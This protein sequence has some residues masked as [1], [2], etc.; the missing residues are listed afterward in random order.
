MERTDIRAAELSEKADI[1]VIDVSFISLI[2]IL[3]SVAEL[4]K[5]DGKI[6]AMMKPQF[7]AG[8]TVADEHKGLILD[9]AVRQQVISDFRE[10]IETQFAVEAEADSGVPGLHGNRERFFVLRPLAANMA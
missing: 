4:V 3:R 1:A 9:E 2:K 10:A 6:V 5:A 7:E 8:K